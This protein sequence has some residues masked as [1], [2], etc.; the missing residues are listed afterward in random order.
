MLARCY[1]P[2]HI[3]Y[4][5]YGGRGIYVFDR[6]TPVPRDDPDKD[7]GPSRA[8]AFG[9]FLRDVG[10]K[11]SKVHTLDRINPREHYVPGNVRWATPKEQGV[12]KRDTHFV[13]HPKTGKR[14]AAA[15]LADELGIRY[16]QLRAKMMRENTWYAIRDEGLSSTEV[17]VPRKVQDNGD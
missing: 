11:P 10:L 17:G 5:E 16:Q 2:K 15:T 7:L 8:T 13:Y 4:P 14:I 6:W 12:N 3:S 9:N 1:N